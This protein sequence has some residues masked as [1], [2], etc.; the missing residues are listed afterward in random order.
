MSR[1]LPPASLTASRI[2][3][4][5]WQLIPQ[6]APSSLLSDDNSSVDLSEDSDV[7]NGARPGTPLLHRRHPPT[8]PTP[9]YHSAHRE[10][11]TKRFPDGWNPPKKISREAMEGMKQLHN[12]DSATFSTAVLADRFRV[13]PEAVRRIL[14]SRWD[15]SPEKKSKILQKEKARK[16]EMALSSPRARERAETIDVERAKRM[17]RSR[18]SQGFDLN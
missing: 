16:Q 4:K 6:T 11:I 7:V 13:S 17:A 15:P 18:G 1:A 12:V 8:S 2:A 9:E 14:K 5:K 3:R 10:A